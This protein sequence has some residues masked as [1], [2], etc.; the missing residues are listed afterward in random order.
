MKVV[1]KVLLICLLLESFSLPIFLLA[2]KH[3]QLE[4]ETAQRLVSMMPWSEVPLEDKRALAD[5]VVSYGELAAMKM[6]AYTALV[7]SAVFIYRRFFRRA[8]RATDAS[9]LGSDSVRP[10]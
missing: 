5:R 3:Y 8:A 7:W 4:S 1:R 2:V 6:L 9:T 10:R